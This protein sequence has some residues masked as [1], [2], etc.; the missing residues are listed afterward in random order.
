MQ[1]WALFHLISKHSL[2]ILNFLAFS[3]L[4]INEFEKRECELNFGWIQLQYVV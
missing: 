1:I 3:L 4:I 2:N